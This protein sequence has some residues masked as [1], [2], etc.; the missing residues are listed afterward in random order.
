MFHIAGKTI[1]LTPE[2]DSS[3]LTSPVTFDEVPKLYAT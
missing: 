3:V 1:F 2:Y